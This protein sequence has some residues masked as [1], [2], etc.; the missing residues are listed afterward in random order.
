M[1]DKFIKTMR[2]TILIITSLI[3]LILT[4]TAVTTPTPSKWE[5]VIFIGA[6]KTH[7]Y[8]YLI[9]RTLP[10]SYY[11]YTDSVFLKKILIEKNQVI[12]RKVIRVIKHIDE[13][14]YGNWKHYEQISDVF[15]VEEYLVEEKV[16][17]SIPSDYLFFAYNLSIGNNEL[18][19]SKENRVVL[20][21][22]LTL[23]QH[24]KLKWDEIGRKDNYVI[25]ISSCFREGTM[26]YIIVQY[27][28]RGDMDYY[29]DIIMLD[30]ET[31]REAQKLTRKRK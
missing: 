21:D 18:S 29:Q 17:Y 7:Y 11:T 2:T 3:C 12:E 15:N 24:L 30:V 8:T 9:K 23:Q 6:N 31:V 1:G 4:A 28:F 22:S 16:Y 5:R 27:G 14:T 10:G 13:T 25:R 19:I 20:L 26:H